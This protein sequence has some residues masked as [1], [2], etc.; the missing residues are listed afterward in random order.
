MSRPQVVNV[1]CNFVYDPERS[2]IEA[3][4]GELVLRRAKTEDEI[5]AAC[6]DATVVLLEFP[7]TPLTARVISALPACRAI[8][9]YGVGIES[10]DQPEA[11][12][13]PTAA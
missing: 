10:V 12:I 6:A 5:I 11:T 13:E 9:R 8:I 2:Q 1:D 3:A 7:H 4:G